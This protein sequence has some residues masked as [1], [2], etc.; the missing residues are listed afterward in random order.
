MTDANG[1]KTDDVARSRDDRA[2]SLQS[3]HKVERHAGAAGPPRPNEWRDDLLMALDDLAS[4]LHDQYER[5]ASEDGLLARIV[6]EQ[7]QL[8]PSVRALRERQSALIEEIDAL[9]QS[10][11]DLS[12]TV[13]VATTR[14]KV[15]EMTA[16]IRELRAWETDIVYEAYAFD[17]GTPG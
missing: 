10:M 9:R 16:E 17:L 7:P 11:S 1:M 8:T 14:S 5:S 15:S 3:L 6:D 4:S 13:D 12:R 2:R